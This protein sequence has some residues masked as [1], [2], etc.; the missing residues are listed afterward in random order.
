MELAQCE[1]TLVSGIKSPIDD[2]YQGMPCMLGSVV[3]RIVGE[4]E[5]GSWG[6]IN[7]LKVFSNPL[8]ATPH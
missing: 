3:G 6:D 2:Y 8:F 7:G 1:P 5:V 4:S